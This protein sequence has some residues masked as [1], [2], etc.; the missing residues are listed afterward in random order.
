MSQ[1]KI[2][3]FFVIKRCRHTLRSFCRLS[4]LAER[5]DNFWLHQS[6]K[7]KEFEKSWYAE[8]KDDQCDYSLKGE[9]EST[10]E[11]MVGNH[12]CLAGPMVDGYLQ[13][14]GKAINNK[15]GRKTTGL[16][17]AIKLYIPWE[18][19]QH[20]F[21]IFQ[22]YGAEFHEVKKNKKRRLVLWVNEDAI[23]RK[24]FNPKRFDG[25]YFLSKRIYK[26]DES[27]KLQLSSI[28][29]LYTSPSPR[30]S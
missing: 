18:V 5:G 30:D 6:E 17:P 24:I 28:C 29:L 23:A 9:M 12:L 20:V 26:K 4:G 11:K 8:I 16:A 13:Q 15:L 25:T 22:G 1:K 27:G 2:F 21:Q 3:L 14:I 10:F 19:A 7:L